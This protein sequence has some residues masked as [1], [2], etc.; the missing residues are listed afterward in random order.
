MRQQTIT[1]IGNLGRIITGKTPSTL[2]PDFY[3]GTI[4]FITPTDMAGTKTIVTTQRYLSTQGRNSVNSSYIPPHSICVSCIGSDMGKVVMT[5]EWAVTNQQINSIIVNESFDYRYIYYLMRTL[6]NRIRNLGKNSTAVPILNKTKFSNIEI[7]VFCDLE[8]QTQIADILSAYDDLIENNQKQI[9]LLEEAAQR[10]YK[11]WFI[12]LHFPGY[13][14]TSIVNGNPEGWGCVPL[15][16]LIKYEIGGGWGSDT[17][18]N[19][20]EVPAYVIRGTDLYDLTHGNC[21]EIPYRYHSKTN[22]M[23]RVLQ[24]GDIIFEVSGGSKTE[25]VA[26]TALIR[27]AILEQFG[28]QVMCASFCKLIRP[29]NA[30]MSQ[31]LYD[32][33]LYLRS[34][35]ETAKYDKRSASSIVNYRWKDFLKQQMIL[36]PSEVVLEKYNNLSGNI[37]QKILSCSR[38]IQTA[39]IARDRLLPKLMSGEIEV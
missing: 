38:A 31:Y 39:K 4:P 10:L 5:H 2:N 18:T 28:G 17:I 15:H 3:G 36:V 8:Y 29:A 21:N 7:K 33:F 35:G 6:E 19:E 20:C 13:E 27:R 30:K 24:D 25:G 26:R 12:D 22:L 37:Y 16:Q 9:K 34:S 1:K 23:A 14:T 11:E 32:T